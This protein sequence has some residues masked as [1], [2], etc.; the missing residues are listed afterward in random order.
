VVDV[1]KNSA[2]Y[3][4]WVGAWFFSELTYYM[5]WDDLDAGINWPIS[6]GIVPIITET[7]G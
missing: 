2:T 6:D 3:G 4:G 1:R 5:V 7:V